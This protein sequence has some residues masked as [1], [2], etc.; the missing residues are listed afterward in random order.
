M[1][2]RI[3]PKKQNKQGDVKYRYKFLWF[4]LCI[5][6]E[7]RW[8]EFAH[9]KYVFDIYES[10]TTDYIC[11]KLEVFPYT[12]THWLPVKFIMNDPV[13]ECKVFNEDV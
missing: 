4:P 7:V 9:I 10:Y 8:L 6:N 5:D 11:G 1:R 13:K 12:V 3:K 2:W